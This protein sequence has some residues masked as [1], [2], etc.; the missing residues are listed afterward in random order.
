MSWEEDYYFRVRPVVGDELF[1]RRL[2]VWDLS[3]GY[4]A[5]EALART[6]LR[7]QT[8]FDSG[9]ADGA[10]CRSLGR[11][12]QGRAR[13]EALAAHCRGHNH[14]ETEWELQ[15]RPA[16]TQALTKELRA[17]ACDLLLAA[18]D[19]RAGEVAQA[20]IDAGVPLVMSFVPQRGVSAIQVVWLPASSADPQEVI[21]ACRTLA[22]L[23][24]ADLDE[25]QHHL[26]GL[27]A[28][29]HALALAKWVLLRGKTPREDLERPVVEQGRALVARGQLDWPWAIRFLTPGRGLAALMSAVQNAAPTY[30]APLSIMQEQRV[31]VLGLGTAS[32]F[33]AEAPLFARTLV[34]VD[35]KEVSPVNPVRQ[36]YSTRHVGKDKAEAACDILSQRL[37]PGAS[38][39]TH[40][41]GE[42]RYLVSAQRS[43]GAATLELSLSEHDSA[44]R[45]EAL[46]DE[47][48]PTLAIVGMG[49]THDDNFLA[50]SELRRR[51]IRHITPSAFP[52]VT[53]FKHI[54]TDGA[55]GPCYDCIQGHLS[56]DA[57]PGPT[58]AREE[59]EMFYGGSQPATL[60]ETYPSAH[61]LLRL[62]LDLSLPRG[63][64]PPYLLRELGGERP[65]FVGANRAERT[66][67]G[68]LYGVEHPFAMV[69]YGLEDV[70][71]PSA[72]GQKCSC[73]RVNLSGR[74]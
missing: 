14:L 70:V 3:Y 58:L 30:R 10:F 69:T 2:A 50:T 67:E 66:A 60:A 62:A 35:C 25:P 17:H 1:A 47:V 4:L 54:V 7:C 63:A 29:S 20:A 6:G 19:A 9:I 40:Q 61:S 32:L 36:I 73:G 64:R 72:A 51:A 44:R 21:D 45:F 42:V 68:W 27:E 65:C 31:L 11:Q 24:L 18:G 26:D 48:R 8:W 39:S 37:E 16:D 46:L 55:V 53:H 15:P 12:H 23:P 56:V 49:R 57:G 33:C 59:R 43:L 52:G 28:R 71:S 34:M 13:G 22:R 38:F 41:K 74:S 5:A